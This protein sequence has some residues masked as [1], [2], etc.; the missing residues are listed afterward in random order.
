M[1][2]AKVLIASAAMKILP[3]DNLDE[4]ARLVVKLSN[5]IGLARSAKLDI[6][7]EMPI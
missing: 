4:A 1:D 7:F 5:I 3:V 2:D 6:N